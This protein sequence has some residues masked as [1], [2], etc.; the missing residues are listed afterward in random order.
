MPLVGS[1]MLGAFAAFIVWTLVRAL[2]NGTIFSDGVAYRVGEQPRMFASTVAVHGLGAL[3]FG[4]LAVG[5]VIT[6][7]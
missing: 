5:D 3:L 6:G 1:M 2:R 4:W 7:F